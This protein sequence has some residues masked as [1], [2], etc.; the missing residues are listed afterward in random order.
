MPGIYICFFIVFLFEGF[1]FLQY[2]SAIFVAKC[3]VVKLC[4]SIASIY[5]ILFAIFFLGMPPLNFLCLCLGN[6]LFLYLLYD[7]NCFSALF[8]SI[9]SVIIMGLYD[10]IVF[11]HGK[12]FRFG[13][14]LLR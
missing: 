1:V 6:F 4:A 13:S 2:C 14:S 9:I 11:C 5:T 7:I 10:G 3:S 8:H 12:I